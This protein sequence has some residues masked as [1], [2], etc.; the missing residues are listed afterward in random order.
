[1]TKVKICGITNLDDA[2]RSMEFG[3]DM[4]GFNFYSKSPRC[5]SPSA[6]RE[7]IGSLGT[8]VSM[9]GVFVNETVEHIVETARFVGLDSIQ[10]HGDES[11]Q[12]VDD[13]RKETHCQIVKAVRVS[14]RF[15][16]EDALDYNVHAILLDSFSAKGRGGSGETFDW[17][18]ANSLWTMVGELWLA[19]GLTA[20]NVRPAIRAVR[21]YAVDACSS[22]E[23]RP[24]FKDPEKLRE[25]ITE[26]KKND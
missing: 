18:I 3:A 17:E 22:L 8:D 21:P 25:F 20:A 14:D 12:F 1:M 5:L 26:A 11:T 15:E 19:G 7:I 13:L 23:L 4:L 24:G 2:R 9:V 10:L 6:A 16:W